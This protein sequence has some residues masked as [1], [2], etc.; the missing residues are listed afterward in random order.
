MPGRNSDPPSPTTPS[1]EGDYNCE[2]C[3]EKT[4]DHTEEQLKNCI[5]QSINKSISKTT[6]FR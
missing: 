1:P 4:F 3:E 5:A 6:W 2:I